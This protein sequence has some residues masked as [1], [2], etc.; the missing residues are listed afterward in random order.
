MSQI[1]YRRGETHYPYF[2]PAFPLDMAEFDD[3]DVKSALANG[4]Y[5]NPSDIP[6]ENETKPT[7]SRRTGSA[8]TVEASGE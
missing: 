7:R 6:E 4:W 8:E 2:W 3:D 1:L 5:K